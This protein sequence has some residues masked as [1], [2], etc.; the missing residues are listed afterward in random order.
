[1]IAHLTKTFNDAELRHKELMEP[2]STRLAEAESADVRRSIMEAGL[3]E[4]FRRRYPM[5]EGCRWPESLEPR[6]EV[7]S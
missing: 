2:Y 7:A 6:V 3:R 1:M 5:P 4:T